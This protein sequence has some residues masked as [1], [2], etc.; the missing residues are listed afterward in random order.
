MRNRIFLIL[1]LILTL[2]KYSSAEEKPKIY[3]PYPIIFVSGIGTRPDDDI[4]KGGSPSHDWPD[5]TVFKEL[6]KNFVINFDKPKDLPQYKYEYEDTK[7]TQALGEL[8]SLEFLFY[9]GRQASVQT[10]AFELKDKI[11][12]IL[13]NEGRYYNLNKYTYADPCSTPK[14]ILVGHSLGGLICRYMLVNYP[15][16][17][18]KVAAVFFL[19][20]PQQGSPMAV[21]GYFLPKEIPYLAEDIQK[22][23]DILKTQKLERWEEYSYKDLIYDEKHKIIGNLRF[24]NWCERG[25]DEGGFLYTSSRD[26]VDNEM[27]SRVLAFDPELVREF[28]KLPKGINEKGAVKAALINNK[29]ASS[30]KHTFVG[31]N[32]A[33]SPQAKDISRDVPEGGLSYDA[34]SV[35]L[36]DLG[37]DVGIDKTHA[38]IGDQY[39]PTR[40][41]LS[42]MA[43][44]KI[45]L[46][47]NL[48]D[49]SFYRNGLWNDG[50]G[51]IN[52]ISQSAVG[53]SHR[54]DAAHSGNIV[55]NIAY[56]PLPPIHV[57]VLIGEREHSATPDIILQAIDDAPV[58][59][60]VRLEKVFS[61]SYPNYYGPIYFLV[62]KISDYLLADI[63]IDEMTIDGSSVIPL[64]FYDPYPPMGNKP[65]YKFGKDF[66]KERDFT[67]TVPEIIIHNPAT[68]QSSPL[69]V[70]F[71]LLPGEFVIRAD[72]IVNGNFYLKIENPAGK[73][74]S[75]AFCYPS[76]ITGYK[77]K[78]SAT[79]WYPQEPPN[80]DAP[81]TYADTLNMAYQNFVNSPSIEFDPMIPVGPGHGP[82]N[83]L[84]GSIYSGASNY[85]SIYGDTWSV[86]MEMNYRS[87]I[88]F[89]LNFGEKKIKEAKFIGS[90]NRF[91]VAPASDF[92]ISVYTG[93]QSTDNNLL[94]TYN[95][96][97]I[98]G[99]MSVQIPLD[100]DTVNGN[101]DNGFVFKPDFSENNCFASTDGSTNPEPASSPPPNSTSYFW[102][103]AGFYDPPVLFVT[104]E[105]DN[106]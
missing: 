12:K 19:G 54:I 57:S 43:A 14:V 20:A 55:A 47:F 77:K 51:V 98:A 74:A 3:M 23:E 36:A 97:S 4:G 6:K 24:M 89:N 33:C 86:S 53:Q 105:E 81:T 1:I 69:N 60:S 62:V 8:Q 5:S 35:L 2:S 103:D 58:I 66:L 75:C 95:T 29:F 21:I 96:A 104:F 46:D 67:V 32:I 52:L 15:E 17:Q 50:D 48:N 18:E 80:P 39:G 40:F 38:I 34:S 7:F 84:G 70:A 63:I 56:P 22:I 106:K 16:M 41:F 85:H 102:R 11:E 44:S 45:G 30:Y 49:Y 101:G 28:D 65:Y 78:G 90:L 59:D 99:G 93:T 9:D 61:N 13:S 31:Q 83:Q 10:D 26:A 82:L 94:S 72:Q 25:K 92:Y 87:F 76:L 71:H 42:A 64:D 79:G 88:N 73:V 68:G 100:V 27:L 91:I 37:L